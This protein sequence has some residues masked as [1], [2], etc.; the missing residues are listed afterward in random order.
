M[1]SLDFLFP[2]HNYPDPNKDQLK[3]SNYFFTLY[4]PFGLW[5]TQNSH[6]LELLGLQVENLG[7]N[8]LSALCKQNTEMVFNNPYDLGF[9]N[10]FL[11]MISKSQ[12]TTEKEN[13]LDFI[14]I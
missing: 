11:N 4:T 5:G 9:G 6:S 2:W 7:I 3:K 10:G 14:K 1:L 8:S 13:K 12:F